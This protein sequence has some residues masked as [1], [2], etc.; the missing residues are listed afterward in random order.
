MVQAEAN[1]NERITKLESKLNEYSKSIGYG[2]GFSI[3]GFV[4][5]PLVR[6]S[7]LLWQCENFVQQLQYKNK[8]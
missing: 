3:F 4:Y 2:H 5:C 6:A 7:T 8:N 1:M